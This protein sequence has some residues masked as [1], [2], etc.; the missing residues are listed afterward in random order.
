MRPLRHQAVVERPH[1]EVDQ[2][3]GHPPLPVPIV[4]LARALG[5]GLQRRAHGGTTDLVEDA[6][7]EDDPVVGGGEGEASCLD[8]FFSSATKP[9]GSPA[10]RAW[11]HVL[12]N[13]ATLCLRA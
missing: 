1:R 3:I 8:S 13:L 11:V 7:Q 2:G 9:S 10:C 6:L 5:Q 4:V 12:R